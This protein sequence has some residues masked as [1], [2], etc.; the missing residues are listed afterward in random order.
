MLQMKKLLILLTI[1]SAGLFSCTKNNESATPGNGVGGSLAR[2]TIAGDYLYTVDNLTLTTYDISDPK[3]PVEKNHQEV[4]WN[5]ETIFPYGKKLF[6][7]GQT[8]MYIYDISQPATPKRLGMAEHLE[9]CDPVV[10]ND[11]V[12]FVSLRSG[13]RCSNAE[14]ALYLYST[15][16]MLHPAE[17]AMEPMDHPE[18]L[19][20]SDST[21]FVC[22]SARIV[23]FNVK[24]PAQPVR[25][26]SLSDNGEIYHD[27]IPYDNLLICMVTGGI[28]LYDITDVQHIALVAKMDY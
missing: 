10:A 22:D 8:G 6:I 21:L 9:S 5:V 4:A 25:T 1:L 20:I 16:D 19:G 15:K 18:G 3:H 13:T 27:V 24:N 28:L 17:L 14:N 12:A 26:D 23:V 2:F 7:G 11:S